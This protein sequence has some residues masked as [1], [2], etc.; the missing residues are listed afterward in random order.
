MSNTLEPGEAPQRRSAL[1]YLWS[2]LAVLTCPCH[3]LLLAILLGGTSA[4]AFLGDH[5]VVAFIG[6]T[7]LFVLFLSAA[8]RAFKARS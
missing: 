4:G 3:L 2:G 1:A 6:L 8:Q 5:Q 7:A